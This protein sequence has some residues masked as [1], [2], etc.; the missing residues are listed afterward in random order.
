[1]L[2]LFCTAASI[3]RV[4]AIEKWLDSKFE[5]LELIFYVLT[6]GVIGGFISASYKLKSITFEKG[7]SRWYF[8]AYGIERLVLS[9]LASI[10]LFFAVKANIVFGFIKDAPNPF[11]GYIILGILAGFSETLIPSLLTKIEKQGLEAKEDK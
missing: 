5:T 1:M 4:A 6:S 3:I 9:I 10:A 7:I 2:V 11:Y 8:L